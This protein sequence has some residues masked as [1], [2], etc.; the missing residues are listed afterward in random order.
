MNTGEAL[1]E[2]RLSKNIS[3]RKLAKISGVSPCTIYR[4]ERNISTPHKTTAKALEN[5][6]D[7]EDAE[8]QTITDTE[9]Q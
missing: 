8:C 3:L 9:N 6:L 1:R 7:A 4:I 2:K 5:A